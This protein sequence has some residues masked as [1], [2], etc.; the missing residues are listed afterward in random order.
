MAILLGFPGNSD[1]FYK[2]FKLIFDALSN[3][4]KIEIINGI[5]NVLQRI[6]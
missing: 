2:S 6:F 5:K 4:N 1:A 3:K